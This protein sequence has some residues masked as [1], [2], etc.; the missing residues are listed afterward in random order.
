VS[1]FGKTIEVTSFGQLMELAPKLEEETYQS[2]IVIIKGLPALDRNEFL[3]FS[4]GL[5]NKL[6]DHE[7]FISWE[8]GNI[9]ELKEEV[10]PKNYLFSKEP[11][12][13]HWD[14]AFHEEPGIL[15][16]NCIETLG[17]KKG[18]TLFANTKKIMEQ[19]NPADIEY[20]E[21]Q[22]AEYETQKLAHYGGRIERELVSIHPR[23]GEKTLRFG[24]EVSTSLNPVKR[25]I[26]DN[27]TLELVLGI[28]QKLYLDR[29]CYA[30][31]WSPGD[32]LLADNH[33]LLHGREGFSGKSEVGKRHLR[34]I[35]LR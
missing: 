12:P 27:K 19:M 34:R 35:Q 5:N 10:D 17:D 2:Q 9:M 11:V 26:K 6:D 22:S 13:F 1:S 23:T 29:Y 32:I 16:F 24:E 3:K 33:A 18:R 8:F 7:K 20:L 21:T 31:D 14:G 4:R 30:H 28:E 25:T 15:V